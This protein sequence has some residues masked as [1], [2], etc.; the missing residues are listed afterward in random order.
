V[1]TAI[2]PQGATLRGEVNPRGLAT[3]FHFEYGLTAVYTASTP[4]TPAGVATVATPVTAA[5]GGL[6]PTTRYHYRLVASNANGVTVGRDRVFRTRVQPAGVTLGVAPNPVRY[7]RPLVFTG[8]VSGPNRAGRVVQLRQDL[9][10]FPGGGFL[11]LGNRVLT[12]PQGAFSITVPSVTI[13]TRFRVVVA[14][15]P[16]LLSPTVDVGVLPR[17]GTRVTRTRVRRH[18]RVHFSGTVRPADV[19]RPYAIQRRR[20]GIWVTVAGAATRPGRSNFALYGKTIRASHS[21]LYRVY[22]GAGNGSTLPN[23]GREIRITIT[24]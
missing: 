7:G 9:F 17:I 8:T 19:G 5:I 15:R 2:S 6:A 12:N 24:R 22:L 20:R 14:G 21:G 18:G 23:T 1:A 16:S 11:N 13:T 10:P 3:T 4:V